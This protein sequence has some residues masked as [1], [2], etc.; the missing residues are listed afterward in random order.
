[1]GFRNEPFLSHET[2]GLCDDLWPSS[3]EFDRYSTRPVHGGALDPLSPPD[4]KWSKNYF[5][6]AP[7][8]HPELSPKGDEL[9]ITYITNSHK[10]S[11]ILHDQRIYYPRFISLPIKG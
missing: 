5:C 10:V 7:K 9:P 8:G 4:A 2:E 6:Y 1:M 11:D 3:R